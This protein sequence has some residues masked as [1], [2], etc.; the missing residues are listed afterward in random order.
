MLFIMDYDVCFP[1]ETLIFSILKGTS[2]LGLFCTGHI[3]HIV[4]TKEVVKQEHINVPSIPGPQS[5]LD[6]DKSI[7]LATNIG[8]DVPNLAP[9]TK[10]RP[11]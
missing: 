6:V 11:V 3:P 7:V 4:G 10:D 9:F 8:H 5:K 2:E 1:G